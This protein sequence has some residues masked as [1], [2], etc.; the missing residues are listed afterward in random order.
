VASVAEIVAGVRAVL[1]AAATARS[2]L[3][4][5]LDRVERAA[6]S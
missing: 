1:G 4:T 5:A 3:L 6:G 2:H